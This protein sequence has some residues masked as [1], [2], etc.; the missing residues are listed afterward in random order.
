MVTIPETHKDLLNAGVGILATNGP[1][2]R[3]QVTALWF[4]Y[5]EADGLVKISLNTERYKVKNLER[6]PHCSFFVLDVANPGRTLELRGD[7]EITPDPDFAFADR[8]GAKYGG[9]NL[10][11]IGAPGHK[12]VV[13]TIHP[14]KVHTF[15]GAPSNESAS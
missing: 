8:I 4:L 5:D 12:R 11:N 10:R 13:V 14:V 15:G 7:A 3:P 9:V 1:D 6:D 2:G